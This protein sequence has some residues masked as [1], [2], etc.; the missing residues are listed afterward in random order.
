MKWF[1]ALCG[2]VLIAGIALSFRTAEHAYE[3]DMLEVNSI[4]RH[5]ENTWQETNTITLP[6]SPLTSTFVEEGASLHTHI[7]NR[8]TL[9]P[10]I[11]DGQYIGSVVFHGQVSE[12]IASTHVRFARTFY[13]QVALLTIVIIIFALYQRQTIITPFKKLERFATRVAAG[14][15]DYPLEM[16]RKNR[17]GAFT[18]SF[19]IMREQLAIARENERQA[20]ISKKELVA[21]LSH[22]IKTPAASIK[23]MAELHQAKHGESNE[24]QV[25]ISKIDQI[26]QLITNMFTATLEELTQLVVTPEEIST[27]EMEEDIRAADYKQKIRPFTLPECVLTIDRLRFKQIMDNIIGNAYKYADTEIEVTGVI[28]GDSLVLAIRD[29]GP[30]VNDEELSLLCEKFYRASNSGGKTGAGLGLYLTTYFLSK[31]DASLTLSNKNGLCAVMRFK[32]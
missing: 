1:I 17:F 11:I 23:V 20:N 29:F 13:I 31:M 18:E 26:D 3:L 2:V 6:E 24:M 9:V 8:D 4:V 28:E 30:G 27:I 16:D 14:D 22:D 32:I 7:Q 19:D 12:T 10:L 5:I 21:S 15:L 25:I